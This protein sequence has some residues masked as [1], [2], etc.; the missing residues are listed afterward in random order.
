MDPKT[1][2]DLNRIRQMRHALECRLGDMPLTTTEVYDIH[3]ALRMLEFLLTKYHQKQDM[4]HIIEDISGM[5]RLA[6][7]GIEKADNIITRQLADSEDACEQMQRVTAGI[8]GENTKI[9]TIS[10]KEN[11]HD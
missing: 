1:D 9:F 3:D 7:E 6:A 11:D 5:V 4:L 8:V 2:H 10:S